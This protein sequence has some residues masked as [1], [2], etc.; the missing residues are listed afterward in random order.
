M[1]PWIFWR[2]HPAMAFIA[3]RD[4]ECPS[5]LDD[6]RITNSASI[7]DLCLA[8]FS[9]GAMPCEFFKMLRCFK[10]DSTSL[11][12]PTHLVNP[13]YSSFHPS[14]QLPS[15]SSYLCPARPPRR[16]RKRGRRSD[17]AHSVAQS[18]PETVGCRGGRCHGEDH[19]DV[20]GISHVYWS[21]LE[22][23]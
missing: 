8:S 23:G 18:F 22:R 3:N 17:G 6:L 1:V 7:R 9:A 13:Q 5:L 2:K 15:A 10:V 21:H 11:V 12:T 20:G 16:L 19:G 14:N 4:P